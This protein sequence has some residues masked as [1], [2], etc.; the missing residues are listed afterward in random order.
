[1]K[2]ALKTFFILILC[3]AVAGGTGYLFFVNLTKSSSAFE[4]INSFVK[5]SSQKELLIDMQQI[6]T[7]GGDRFNT[8]IGTYNDMQQSLQCLN[9]CLIDFENSTAEHI[10]CTKLDKLVSQTSDIK[11]M[12]NEYNIKSQNSTF[13]KYEGSNNIYESFA[14]F[15]A[16]YA[17]YVLA[18]NM[19]VKKYVSST[20]VDVKFDIIDVY[21][22]VVKNSLQNL[23]VYETNNFDNLN[24]MN[25]HFQLK[26]GYLV[27]Q[28]PN[29]NFASENN[30]FIEQYKQCNAL[31]FASN[32]NA[33]LILADVNSTN[34]E[35]RA[36]YYLKIILGA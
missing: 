13:N 22:N 18:V 10:L 17:D 23:K 14:D 33:N 8:I 12:V 9:A 2:K 19:E 26:N 35:L 1:M 24:Y 32:L 36:G 25:S 30:K 21:A 31:S 16:N 11:A 3:L 7:Y 6:S 4:N 27:S 34:V 28:N 5:S 15:V 20:N 29:G